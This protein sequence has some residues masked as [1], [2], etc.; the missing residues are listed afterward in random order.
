MVLLQGCYNIKYS[1]FCQA[2]PQP[3]EFAIAIEGNL[4]NAEAIAQKIDLPHNSMRDKL[5]LAFE[6]EDHFLTQLNSRDYDILGVIRGGGG[7]HHNLAGL[8]KMMLRRAAKKGGDVVLFYNSGHV[9]R[10][11]SYSTP[12][13]ATTDIYGSVYGGHG[14]SYG[15]GTAQTTYTPSQTYSGTDY[16]PYTTGMV[17]KYAPEAEITRQKTRALSEAALTLYIAEIKKL[18]A[19]SQITYE[20]VDMRLLQ[21]LDRL[22]DS[23]VIAEQIPSIEE[24]KA[25]AKTPK[26]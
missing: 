26:K 1:P 9:A 21:L 2:I 14:Y 17:L 4:G 11:Y 7:G 23:E 12:G 10:D 3:T 15:Y 16:Y 8:K 22:T 19:E 6:F 5:S 25:G 18:C 24:R 20:E 13:Y